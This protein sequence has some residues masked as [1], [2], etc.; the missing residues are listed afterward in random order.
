[1]DLN[2]DG[3]VTLDEFLEC[4]RNDETISR[5]MAMFDTNFWQ[6]AQV[7]DDPQ[8]Q[9]TNNNNATINNGGPASITGKKT[10]KPSSAPKTYHH[11]HQQ[12]HPNFQHPAPSAC[13]FTHNYQYNQ[14]IYH[15][16]YP[17]QVSSVV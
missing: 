4:C 13:Q 17:Q 7:T 2:Q 16:Y 12:H 10:N 11:H 15:Q 1:M 5:S 3:V 14:P 9:A 8:K 6:D